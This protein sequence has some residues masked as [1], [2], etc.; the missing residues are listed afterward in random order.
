[1]TS[2]SF[3]LGEQSTNCSAFYTQSHSLLEWEAVTQT[4]I[5]SESCATYFASNPFIY[6]V[7]IYL[8][9]TK[10]SGPLLYMQ[11][12]LIMLRIKL[13]HICS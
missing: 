12:F 7:F 11:L 5:N 10:L 6:F 13:H 2:L 4:D 3:S 9:M 1:M 8:D